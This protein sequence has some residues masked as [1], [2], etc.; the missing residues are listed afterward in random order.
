ML[1]SLEAEETEA[2]VLLVEPH[3]GWWLVHPTWEAEGARRE[4]A[5]G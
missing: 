1:G 4:E 2:A 5:A 3:G